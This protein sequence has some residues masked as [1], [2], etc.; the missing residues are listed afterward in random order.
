MKK[1][2][3]FNIVDIFKH[4]PNCLICDTQLNWAG[5]GVWWIAHIEDT[6]KLPLNSGSDTFIQ[7]QRI[8]R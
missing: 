7:K 2:S 6:H 3:C 5:G 8:I 1:T 4:Y